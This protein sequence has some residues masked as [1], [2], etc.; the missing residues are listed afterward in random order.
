MNCWIRK[1]PR[2]D[3]DSH[4]LNAS[5]FCGRT[6]ANW[7][8]KYAIWPAH[9]GQALE[10]R[11]PGNVFEDGQPTPTRNRQLQRANAGELRGAIQ[12]GVEQDARV[13]DDDYQTSRF[14][15]SAGAQPRHHSWRQD[16]PGSTQAYAASTPIGT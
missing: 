5:A 16:R 12:V 11:V 6:V 4:W 1:D 3:G 8:S 9:D 15:L 14:H 2:L 10:V 13:A 7:V